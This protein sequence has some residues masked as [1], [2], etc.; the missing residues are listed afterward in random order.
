[1]SINMELKNKIRA[2][3]QESLV[4]RR[5]TIFLA[6]I[7]VQEY[8]PWKYLS[9]SQK[10]EKL[11]IFAKSNGITNVNSR[12]ISDYKLCDIHYQINTGTVSNVIFVKKC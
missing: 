6:T 10:I 11:L 7:D 2:L 5:S 12:N 9:R 3:Y 8:L 1:M 4:N